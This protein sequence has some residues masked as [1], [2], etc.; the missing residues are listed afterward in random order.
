MGGYGNQIAQDMSQSFTQAKEHKRNRQEQLQD[1]QRQQKLGVYA[2]LHNQGRISTVELGHAIEDIYHDAEPEKKMSILGRLLN[3]KKAQQQH[4]DFLQGKQKRATE[5]QG[6]MTG[7]IPTKQLQDEAQK[8]KLELAQAQHPPKAAATAAPES[9]YQKATIALRQASQ[10]L[11][12]AQ[13]E[14][15]QDPNN[16]TAKLKLKQAAS[17]AENADARMKMA[18]ARYKGTW[19]GVPLA[20]D[21]LTTEGQPVGPANAPNVRPVGAQRVASGRATSAIEQIED[22]KQI[23]KQRGDLFGPGAGRVT[24]LTQ[25]LGSQDKEAQRLTAAVN[26][27]SAHLQS[28]FGGTS[29]PQSQEIAKIAADFKHNP[30]ASIAALEQYAKAAE[31]IKGLGA[32]RT[33]GG[34]A[35]PSSS[36]GKGAPAPKGGKGKIKDGRTGTIDASE[37]DAKTM[38]KVK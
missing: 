11:K 19:N 29:A 2:D 21:I 36:G 20:G 33:V 6:I 30:E 5:E 35:T 38:T 14:A 17:A 4:N 25:W 34:G 26:T 15:S 16:P 3:R 9:D 10:E 28:A 31:T 13:F 8:R 1:E 24:Q 23:L 37:F 22:A 7:A 12:Q 27:L 32:Y 18:E